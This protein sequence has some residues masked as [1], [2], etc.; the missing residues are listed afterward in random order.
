MASSAQSDTSKDDLPWD[1]RSAPRDVQDFYRRIV[2]EGVTPR[3]AEMVAL[4]QP[5]G[6]RGTDRTFMENRLNNQ[7]FDSM[8]KDHAENLITL[9]KRAGINPA[10][11]YY[12]SGIADGR[13]AS[14]PAAWVDSVNDVKRVA[15]ERNLTVEGAVEHKGIPMPRPKTQALSEAATRDLMR[16]ERRRQPTMKKG[17]LREYVIDRYGRKPKD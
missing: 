10:G 12:C 7:Q 9:A 14:D 8:P 15:K 11:K 16:E 1:I 13:G 3:F 5:P 17:E 6:L 2:G 4:Q